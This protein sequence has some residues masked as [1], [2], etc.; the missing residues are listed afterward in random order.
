MIK[1]ETSRFGFIEFQKED[2]L[3]FPEG[4]IGFESLRNFCF[5][6]DPLDEIFIW[7][8]S[9][10]E[11]QVAF[12]VL[13]PILF[14][15]NDKV[16]LSKNDLEVLHLKKDEWYQCFYIIA[17]PENPDQMTANL[18]APLVLNLKEKKGKQCVLQ[19]PSLSIA[20][21]IFSKLRSHLIQ[22][23]SFSSKSQVQKS[24]N[25]KSSVL[26]I[27]RLYS[28][29]KGEKRGKRFNVGQEDQSKNPLKGELK[30]YEFKNQLKGSLEHKMES[31]SKKT[32]QEP[33]SLEKEKV[34]NTTEV[35][36]E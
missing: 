31:S 13:E 12:P 19:D 4:L 26:S 2:L 32:S 9:Y 3:F 6:N 15:S 18:K 28:F 16:E 33:N 30:G 24:L 35:E 25:Q 11:A 5:L 8:Q 36:I 23:S 21:P 27:E 1:I 10:E 7:L 29:Y 22:S 34:R 20:K 14:S 17:I